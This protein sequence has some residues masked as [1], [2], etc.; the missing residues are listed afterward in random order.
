MATALDQL[1]TCIEAVVPISHGNR[2]TAAQDAEI[3]RSRFLPP[4]SFT[5]QKDLADATTAAIHSFSNVLPCP[6]N[7]GSYAGPSWCCGAQEGTEEAR[8]GCCQT[9]LFTPDFGVFANAE[10][11]ANT[12]DPKPSTLATSSSHT[13]TSPSFVSSPTSSI[14]SEPA[15]ISTSTFTP[16]QATVGPSS[17]PAHT[18]QKS[19]AVGAGVGVP[20]GALSLFGLV[21]LF[22]RE[23]RRRIHAQKT[24]DNVYTAAQ[25]RAREREG[26][27]AGGYSS[28]NHILLQELESR[29][30]GP[31][32]ID[33]REVHEA[34]GGF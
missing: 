26:T 1:D 33:S 12:T 31:N 6:V 21:F 22:L 7:N 24:T 8:A 27:T 32:E 29:Q 15:F 20:V 10:A 9:T 16:T 4:K 28:R 3:V 30:R 25:E 18:S 23:R 11:V 19:V 34:N 17:V 2:Q 14:S 5:P 13:A